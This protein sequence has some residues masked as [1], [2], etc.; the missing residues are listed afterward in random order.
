MQLTVADNYGK[1]VQLYV[2]RDNAWELL[3][4]DRDGNTLTALVPASAV[5]DGTVRVLIQART[6]ANTPYTQADDFNTEVGDN[7]DWDGT[8]V[9]ENYDFAIAWYTDTQY[10]AER[11]NQHYQDMVSWII[12]KKDDLNIKYVFHT[13][14]IA[15]EF[16]EEYQFAFARSQ[17][18]RLEDAGI[19]TGVL[20]GNHDV[21]HGNMVYDLYWKYFGEEYYKDKSYYGGS[22]KNNLGHYDVVEVDG[23]EILFISI[24]WGHL[25]LRDCLDQLRSGCTPRYPRHHYHPWRHQCHGNRELHQPHS[26]QRCVQEPSPGH[27]YPQR[28]LSR[29]LRQLC[30]AD[31]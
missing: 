8:A 16:N 12:D 18:K 13:G 22:Y 20:G 26:A 4:V 11:Y 24:S 31:Q 27:G 30:G 21:A 28:S 14:D 7:D 19:P 23:E 3:D 25:H 10:Y 9:P 2:L 1:D 15:D 5:A 29:F 6:I 17:Q